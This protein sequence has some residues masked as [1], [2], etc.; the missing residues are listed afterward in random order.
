MQDAYIRWSSLYIGESMFQEGRVYLDKS[1]RLLIYE[2]GHLHTTTGNRCKVGNVDDYTLT[3][4]NKEDVDDFLEEKK[5]SR[6][7]RRY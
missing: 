7:R 5:K 3:R 6:Y 4:L 1:N 2:K